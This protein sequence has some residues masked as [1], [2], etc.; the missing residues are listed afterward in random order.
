MSDHK[1]PPCDHDECGPTRC[2]YNQ[3]TPTGSEPHAAESVV[4][5]TKE[6]EDLRL[7][8]KALFVNKIAVG[9]DGYDYMIFVGD[10]EYKL[11]CDR[12]TGER[13][14]TPEIRSILKVSLTGHFYLNDKR[15]EAE[16]P[17]YICDVRGRLPLDCSTY[18]IHTDE[19]GKLMSSPLPNSHRI[20]SGT[21][22]YYATQGY[23]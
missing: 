8:V 19:P 13:V 12:D 4:R 14:L 11:L 7:L 20:E 2:I 21:K 3:Q 18:S 10:S 1:L 22:L 15:Y 9:I 23:I 6:N 16:E 5:L 17:I